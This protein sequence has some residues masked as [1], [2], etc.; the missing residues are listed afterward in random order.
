MKCSIPECPNIPERNG[1]CSSHNRSARKA[2]S[3]ALKVKKKQKPIKH[4]S[5]KL[6]NYYK[7]YVDIRDEW[8]KGKMCVVFP[9]LPAIEPHHAHGRSYN[10]FYDD[11]AVYNDI[12]LLLDTRFWKPVSRAGH[13]QIEGSPEWAYKMGFSESRLSKK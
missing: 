2:E 10:E 11:W 6:A 5:N 1:T 4:M 8:I 13:I 3:D 12:P 9:A 7:R